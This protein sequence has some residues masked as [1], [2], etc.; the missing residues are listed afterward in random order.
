MDVASIPASA[1]S[2]V[3]AVSL[4]LGCAQQPELIVIQ[5]V[6]VIDGT[7]AAPRSGMSVVVEGR[8]IKAVTRGHSVRHPPSA[9]VIDGSGKYLIPGLWDMH[10][11]LRDLDATVP[12]FVVNGVT[13]VRDMGSDL[14][15]TL[16]LRRRIETGEVVG[17]RIRTAGL[18][19]ESRSWLGQYVDLMREQGADEERI[20][21]FLRS[22]ITAGDPA[23][24]RAAVD[25]L[26]GLGV[27][28]VKVRHA[29]SQ[30]VLEA[31]GAAAAEAGVQLVGHYVWVTG[32]AES[33]RAG[34]RSIEHNILPGFHQKSQEE[35]HDIFSALQEN[36]THF[37]PTLVTNE[38]QTMSFDRLLALAEDRAGSV[39]YRNRYV[40]ASIRESWLE[41]IE[42]DAADTDRPPPE[43]IQQ[44][45]DDSNAFLR[46]ARASGVKMLAG[47]DVPTT[48]TFVGF[49]LHDELALLVDT[50]GLSPMEALQSATADAAAF[51]GM[52]DDVGTIAEGMRADLILV[53]ANPLVDITNT[54]RIDTVIAD[55]RVFDRAAREQLLFEIES[56]VAVALSGPATSSSAGATTPQAS[57]SLADRVAAFLS[58]YVEGGN[59]SGVVLVARDA[60]VVLQTAFGQADYEQGVAMRPDYTFCIG[61]V[62]KTFTAAA[63]L[64]LVERGDIDL[65]APVGLYVPQF[66]HGGRIAVRHLLEH[67]SGLPNLFLRPDYAQLEV[68]RYE[69]PSDVLELVRG[70]ELAADPGELYAYNNLNYVALAWLLEEVSGTPYA[71]FLNVEVLEPLGIGAIGLLRSPDGVPAGLARGHDPV[72]E[73]DRRPERYADRSI[74]AGAGSTF[75]DA[76]SLWE[77]FAAISDRKFL[78]SLSDSVVFEY[79]GRSELVAGHPAIVATGWDGIGYSA[80]VIFLRDERLATVVLANLSIAQVA[81]EIAEGVTAIALGE[82]PART[83]P[84]PRHLPGDSLSAYVGRYRFGQDFYVPGGALE[85]AVRNG[86]LHDDSRHPPAALIPLSGGGFLYR[87][88]WATVVFERDA[89]GRIVQLTFDRRFVAI[90]EG[91]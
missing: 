19:V 16:A 9:R 89:E 52:D 18:A 87:P 80:H 17:P 37:T 38:S 47:T 66:P 24:A 53:E 29:E 7:G 51:L 22:R 5:D 44:M 81:G 27:D 36:G 45:I 76:E 42:L 49:S 88:V 58:P 67:R 85:L 77:W 8:R 1:L 72:G 28:F 64:T 56:A 71:T 2:L 61:S 34:Q 35:K 25:S 73:R 31:L 48:G 6:T 84:T 39:D 91:D 69:R 54:R 26:I 20:A 82:S 59:F 12:L 65:D 3:L 62:S 70:T 33:A 21:S 68:R 30:A 15:A 43:V 55:G 14:A 75:T 90:R 23:E 40:S 13:T 41:T 11:H 78:P 50:Y 32:L 4:W 83:A 79:M 57:D 60:E 46:D 86:G 74:L 63:V 10:V